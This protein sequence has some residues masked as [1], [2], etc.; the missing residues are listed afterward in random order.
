M[1]FIL[2]IAKYD[3]FWYKNYPLAKGIKLG[4]IGLFWTKECPIEMAVKW[5]HKYE[6]ELLNKETEWVI[7]TDFGDVYVTSQD[8]F[9]ELIRLIN[10]E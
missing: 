6:E 1:N 2:E 4:W 10:K 3:G 7:T 9:D 5:K 8:I